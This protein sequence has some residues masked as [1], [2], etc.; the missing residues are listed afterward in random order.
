MSCGDLESESRAHTAITISSRRL[1]TAAGYTRA[2]LAA[3]AGRDVLAVGEVNE[4]NFHVVIEAQP[5]AERTII[6]LTAGPL[7]GDAHPSKPY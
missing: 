4:S 2:E 7:I 5:A 6:D 1:G 3:L